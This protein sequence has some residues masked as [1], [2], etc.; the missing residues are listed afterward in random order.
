VTATF[1]H[2][3]CADLS[4]SEIAS[5]TSGLGTTKSGTDYIAECQAAGVPVPT[6]V[7][8]GTWENHGILS[9]EFIETSLFAEVWSWVSSSPRG[10]CLSLPRHTAEV[11]GLTKIT[12]VIC[13]GIESS[14]VCYF[15][16][17][18]D[19]YFEG[20]WTRGPHPMSDFVAGAAL[21][22]NGG[23]ECTDCHAGENPFIVHPDEPAFRDFAADRS[24]D[25]RFP[26]EWPE[27]I[28]VADWPMNPGPIES[29]GAVPGGE[30]G[31][32]TAGCHVRGPGSGRLPMGSM[33]ELT[34]WCYTILPTALSRPT[35]PP[36]GAPGN[37]TAH[38]T[39][40][41]RLCQTPRSGVIRFGTGPTDNVMVLSPPR[42][43]TPLY[44]CG[45]A[46][47]V[48]GMRHG[49]EVIL[50]RD[51][52]TVAT[53]TAQGERVEFLRSELG[54]MGMAG[55]WT[56]RQRV[57]GVTSGPSAAVTARDILADY[58]GGLPAP[59]IDPTLIHACAQSIAVMHVAGTTLEVRRVRLG[60]TTTWTVGG[61]SSGYSAVG[62]DAPLAVQ[63]TL[64]VRQRCGSGAF[65]AWSTPGASVRAEP[66]PVPRPFI[67]DEE[68]FAGQRVVTVTGLSE[69]ARV[70]LGP[71]MSGSWPVGYLDVG[72]GAAL[73]RTLLTTDAL[74]LRQ[75]LCTVS[76]PDVIVRPRP[77]SELPAP[78]IAT[79]LSGTR[80]V[81]FSEY[82]PS[83]VLRVSSGGIEIGDGSGYELTLSR[84]LVIG[85]TLVVTQEFP[86]TCAAQSHFEAVVR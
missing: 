85:E 18:G 1:F 7:N 53:K 82:V 21:A 23:G 68:A 67:D 59:R 15:D 54:A 57:G 33:D 3:G 48:I 41:N 84:D 20:G 28:V 64:S 13:M 65:S 76:A 5:S 55:T 45:E 40:L 58:P 56:A 50:E 34:S 6:M 17:P 30:R 46:I 69:G 25:L 35:M 9:N 77:C 43:L 74:P 16:S 36:A 47:G 63:D 26:D 61:N 81:T 62:T 83:S 73:G 11:G 37:Y 49:A 79:P 42:I 32:T 86:G 10:I 78:E 75:R 19:V 24:I 12:G 22:T 52:A 31:C 2:V 27:P 4:D 8:D 70:E 72:I 14:K 60:T 38:R 51:G 80:F 71:L 39:V 29:L 66:A 44:L